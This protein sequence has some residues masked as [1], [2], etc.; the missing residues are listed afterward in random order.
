MKYLPR[1]TDPKD[2][3]ESNRSNCLG[4]DAQNSALFFQFD[5][6]Q[7]SQLG[8]GDFV[9]GLQAVFNFVFSGITEFIRSGTSLDEYLPT[10]LEVG[11]PE[12]EELLE[13]IGGIGLFFDDWDDPGVMIGGKVAMRA[14]GFPLHLSKYL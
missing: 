2:E 9:I 10:V 1:L 5:V 8:N 11:Q 7:D 4:F 12:W 6:M 13:P 3:Y 14:F